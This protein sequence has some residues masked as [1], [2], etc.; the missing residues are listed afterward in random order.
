M[1]VHR[2][3]P[4]TRLRLCGCGEQDVVKATMLFLAFL[5][6]SQIHPS[7]LQSPLRL[8]LPE[9]HG[10]PAR[11]IPFERPRPF[12]VIHL[13]IHQLACPAV[14]SRRRTS[15]I[16]SKSLELVIVMPRLKC[17]N[18]CKLLV[19]APAPRAPQKARISLSK[20]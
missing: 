16:A 1:T 6:A 18:P 5:L 3:R 20:M 14:C 12:I 2:R 17:L 7:R 10:D 4:V 11:R 9:A 19:Y 15:L 8:I 13:Y